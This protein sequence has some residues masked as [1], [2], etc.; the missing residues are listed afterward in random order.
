MSTRNPAV[1]LRLVEHL[2]ELLLY[3]ALGGAVICLRHVD[4]RVVLLYMSL[5]SVEAS[6]TSF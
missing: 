4:I 6:Y 3:R 2:G 1:K 5:L